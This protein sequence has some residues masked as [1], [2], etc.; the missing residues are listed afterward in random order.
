M[1]KVPK[2]KNFEDFLSKQEHKLKLET[3]RL[4]T[5]LLTNWGVTSQVAGSDHRQ[6]KNLT[7]VQPCEAFTLETRME[8]S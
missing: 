2:A 1:K 3:T 6:I 4:K 5:L 7:L 8:Y